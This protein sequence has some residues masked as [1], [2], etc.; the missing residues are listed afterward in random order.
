MT[1]R[2]TLTAIGFVILGVTRLCANPSNPDPGT[3]A[4]TNL[5]RA[6]VTITYD[7]QATESFSP[8]RAVVRRMVEVGLRGMTAKNSADE[9]WHSLIQTNETVG[10]K[11][12][13]A[14][15][16]VSGTR[17]SVVRALIESLL[18]SGFPA[19]QII[20]W[21]KRMVDLR[22]SGWVTLAEEL[23]VNCAAA[24]DADWDTSKFYESPIPPRLIAG[25]REFGI[26]SKDGVGR[27]SYISR[28][29]TQ[30]IT[31]IVSV[32]PLLSHN[33]TGVNGH[34]TGLA[35]GSIDNS[36]R[37]AGEPDRL[38]EVVPE[39]C[40]LDDLMPKVVFGVSDALI[41]QFRGEE[42]TLLHYAKAL[43]ELRFSKDLVALDS[44]ALA[45]IETARI[46]NRTG[47]EKPRTTDLYANAELIEMGVANR[48]RID[49]RRVP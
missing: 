7:A 44:L 14:P 19:P 46:E 39:I 29:L 1:A 48:S 27:K 6:A 36:L 23:G 17:T 45:D 35:L 2:R 24:E 38:A 31:K 8:N 41:C 11:V 13:S 12:T 49:V 37:F 18:Q 10:F 43:N 34:L 9:A 22:S 33:Y 4:T 16:P 42:T 15:G 26:K 3:G 25:D 5:T 47:T 40:A 21:D 20:I 30:R 32:A 28:L